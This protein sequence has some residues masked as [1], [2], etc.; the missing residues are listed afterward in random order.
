MKEKDDSK[1]YSLPQEALRS[2]YRPDGYREFPTKH[3]THASELE[4]SR[5]QTDVIV[6]LKS[7]YQKNC[8]GDNQGYDEENDGNQ[9]H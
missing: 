8:E 5:P 2:E 4:K 9:Q 7:L 3:A 1:K 6:T